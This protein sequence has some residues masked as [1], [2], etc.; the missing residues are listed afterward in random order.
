MHINGG[1]GVLEKN[2]A[3][4]NAHRFFLR[5]QVHIAPLENNRNRGFSQDKYI[6][7][8]GSWSA[9]HQHEAGR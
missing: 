4:L 3:S 9:L 8:A 1:I 5:A 2:Y 6:P 7:L